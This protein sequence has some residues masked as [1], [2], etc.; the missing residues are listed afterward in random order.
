[1]QLNGASRLTLILGDPIAQVKSPAGMTAAMQ[2]RGHNALVVPVHVSPA[3]L[4]ALLAG[5]ALAQNL[6]GIIATI[7]H[8]F[9]C[10]AHCASTSPRAQTL[11]AVNIMRRTPA[12]AWH[13]DML[14]GEG[15][16]AAM[17]AKGRDP[18]GETALLGG[19]GGAGS[20]IGLALLQAGVARLAV[21]EPDATRRAALIAKLAAQHPG[22]VVEGSANPRGHGLILNASPAGMRAADPLPVDITALE[23]S[24]Y[25]G[26]VI[27]APE[28]P[29]LIAAA[30]ARGCSTGTGTE[31]YAEVQKL[32]LEFLLT[33]H[34]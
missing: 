27:T 30:R 23:P 16:V 9:A 32:M 29:P 24:L 4:G 5:A 34:A 18:A 3:N 19:A 14:D 1:M 6:D 13:G 10:F 15:F 26:C 17:R 31:M 25:V 2:A 28:V 20:A 12:G 22:R 21:H 8:K 11:G 33:P 7:P